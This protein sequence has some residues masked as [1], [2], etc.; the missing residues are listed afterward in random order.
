MNIS[1]TTQ[2]GNFWIH[3]R[4]SLG[5]ILISPHLLFYLHQRVQTGSGAHPCVP[6]VLSLGIKRPGCEADRSPPSNADVKNAWS[7][8]ITPP[9]RLH[10][11]VLSQ[12]SKAQV[13]RRGAQLQKKHRDNFTIICCYPTFRRITV[14]NQ[15]PLLSEHFDCRHCVS[16]K[17]NGNKEMRGQLDSEN[18]WLSQRGET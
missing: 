4:I 11:E 15:V 10:D 6:G 14:C 17:R 8:S 1:L 18:N 7:Y 9:I 2:S 5:S 16:K 12:L 13:S 3:P